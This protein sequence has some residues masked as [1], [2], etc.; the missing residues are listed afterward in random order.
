M[1]TVGGTRVAADS[2]EDEEDEVESAEIKPL[3]D[4]DERENLEAE[5][6]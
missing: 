5:L 4:D 3:G 6:S 1:K 2:A